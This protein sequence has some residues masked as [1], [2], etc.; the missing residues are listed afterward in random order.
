MEKLKAKDYRKLYIAAVY[1][2]GA[3]YSDDL[4]FVL[5]HYYPNLT[6]K[7]LQNDLKARVPKF[8]REYAVFTTYKQ[9]KYI[10]T[11]EFND[12]DDL[13]YLFETKKDKPTYIP[14][15]LEDFLKYSD[16]FF[17]GEDAR[18]YQERIFEYLTTK[19]KTNEQE[20][21][22]YI[23]LITAGIKTNRLNDAIQEV[24]GNI[25][26]NN[27]NEMKSIISIINDL[28]NNS[29]MPENN[30]FTP[31]ELSSLYQ[32]DPQDMELT[33]GPNMKKMF[34]EGVLNPHQ[35]L[36]ELKKSNLPLKAK[37]S[38]EKEIKEIIEEM[39]NHQA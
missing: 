31:K 8:T 21:Y 28:N 26:F 32:S 34:Y 30:G 16:G 4:H 27:E 37:E 7:E 19:V 38:F 33:I 36:E 20:A 3:I 14:P 1:L 5:K 18:A 2:Y 15:T 29:R 24:L 39:N 10:I 23:L 13:D 9:N 35:Y 17:L 12:N 25:K 11:S 6:K 22:R